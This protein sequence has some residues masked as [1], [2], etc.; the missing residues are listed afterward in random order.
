MPT[1]GTVR[2]PI[3]TQKPIINDETVAAPPLVNVCA[4]VTLIGNV[5]CR[6]KPPMAK[7]GGETERRQMRRQRH[8]QR[9]RSGR[10][11][12][13]LRADAIGGGSAQETADAASAIQRHCRARLADRPALLRQQ[14]RR[15]DHGRISGTV[16]HDH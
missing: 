4:N 10:R 6:S 14:C 16:R 7:H 8:E 15:K 2:L 11:I 1:S 9:R 12:A 5:D 13:F 3:L